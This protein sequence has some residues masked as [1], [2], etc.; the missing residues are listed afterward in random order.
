MDINYSGADSLSQK[1]IN[2]KS[3]IYNNL[4]TLNNLRLY[5]RSYICAEGN[6]I[7][8]EDRMEQADDTF[9]SGCCLLAGQFTQ[10]QG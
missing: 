6:S 10:G 5:S 9:S 1:S 3:E 4:A 8:D 7:L 2:K